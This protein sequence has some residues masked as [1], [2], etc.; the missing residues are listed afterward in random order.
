MN[1][2]NIAAASALDFTSQGRRDYFVE[3]EHPS[4]WGHYLIPLTVLV[5]PN[6]EA[7]R[8]LLAIGATHGNEYEGPIALKHLLAVPLRKIQIQQKQSRKRRL[9]IGFRTLNEA[10]RLLAVFHVM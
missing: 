2:R 6:A 1:E 3:L 9:L 4:I 8:G 5:G 7:G 10:D